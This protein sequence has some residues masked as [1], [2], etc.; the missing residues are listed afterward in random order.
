MEAQP[1]GP[2]ASDVLALRDQ[3]LPDDIF[4]DLGQNDALVAPRPEA[5]LRVSDLVVPN[6]PPASPAGP[7]RVPAR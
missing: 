5:P 1:V 4:A 3:A 7:G 2:A 6:R